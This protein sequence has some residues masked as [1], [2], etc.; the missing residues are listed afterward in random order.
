[1]LLAAYV[2]M[3]VRTTQLGVCLQ[4]MLATAVVY[5][6]GAPLVDFVFNKYDAKTHSVLVSLYTGR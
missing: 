4:V 2:E 3:L 6:T 5:H 1:M